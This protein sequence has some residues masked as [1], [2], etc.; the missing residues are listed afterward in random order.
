[1]AEVLNAF[2]K[3]HVTLFSCRVSVSAVVIESWDNSG[4]EL[5]TQDCEELRDVYDRLW[6]R[7]YFI[8]IGSTSGCFAAL[9]FRY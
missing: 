5:T 2:F 6:L 3:K 7:P 4:T 9:L 8:V 1:M